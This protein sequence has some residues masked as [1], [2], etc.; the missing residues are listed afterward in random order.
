MGTLSELGKKF[1]TDKGTIHSYLDYYESVFERIR[2]DPIVILEIGIYEGASLEMWAEYFPMAEIH[3]I[4]INID[5]VKMSV[6]ENQ[7]IKLYKYSSVCLKDLS[8]FNENQF[9]IIID[10]G[11]LNAYL[12]WKEKL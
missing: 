9:D 10:E 11:I 6:K 12:S 4:D 8:N 3:G 2:F 7:K 5:R 1:N